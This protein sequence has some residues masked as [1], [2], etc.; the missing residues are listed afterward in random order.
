M[1]N[2][3]KALCV[4]SIYSLYSSNLPIIKYSS[5]S[6]LNMFSEYDMDTQICF[7]DYFE[8]LY[9]PSECDACDNRK[10]GIGMDDSAAIKVG[11]FLGGENG[12]EE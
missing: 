11:I 6:E 2:I 5:D 7:S 10:Y 3:Q 4:C 12:Y 8:S 1:I 9:Q